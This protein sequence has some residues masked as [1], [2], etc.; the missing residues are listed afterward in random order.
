[1]PGTLERAFRLD[2]G[3]FEQPASHDGHPVRDEWLIIAL[4]ARC[5]P[6]GASPP[7]WY[8]MKL[9]PHPSACS[10]VHV[11][12]FPPPAR[13][14]PAAMTDGRNW[15]SLPVTAMPLACHWQPSQ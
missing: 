14:A 8:A 6:N 9:V 3:P 12:V 1:M 13:G 11:V 10:A 2:R 7:T 5:V 15:K 4:A